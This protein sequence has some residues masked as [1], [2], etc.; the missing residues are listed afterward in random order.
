MEVALY[1]PELWWPVLQMGS[2]CVLKEMYIRE[3][4]GGSYLIVEMTIMTCS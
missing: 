1:I 2:T 4:T 3:Q